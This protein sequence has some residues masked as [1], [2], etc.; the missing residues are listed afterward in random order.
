MSKLGCMCGHNISDQTD[1]LPYKAYIREDEDIQKPIELLADI[2]A[3]YYE[4]R[5]QGQ[6]DEFVKEFEIGRGEPEDYAAIQ[7]K[8]LH[9]KPLRDVLF[10]LIYPFWNN[11]DRSIYECE[12]CGRLL[13]ELEDGKSV[14]GG[15]FV[16]YQPETGTRHVLWSR[17]NHNPYG[18]R[19]E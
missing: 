13:V 17:H 4:A 1:F 14:E 6:G 10:H 12:R 15:I 9:D 16:T 2:L 11:F 3:R 5:Q 7:A 8:Y 18:S 19:D